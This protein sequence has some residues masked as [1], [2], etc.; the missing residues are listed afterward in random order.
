MGAYGYAKCTTPYA[1]P[2]ELTVRIGFNTW[3][4]QTGQKN[5]F[6]CCKPI[7]GDKNR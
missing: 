6:Y 4:W 5:L 7:G 1:Q 3:Q 2:E